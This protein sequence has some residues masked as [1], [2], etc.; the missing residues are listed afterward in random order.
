[1]KTQGILGTFFLA[2]TRYP[3]ALRAAQDQI[4]R[5]IGNDRLLDFADRP[6]LPYIDAIVEELY[7]YAV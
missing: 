7:R 1:M 5:V 4:D 6:L 2:M 3:Y